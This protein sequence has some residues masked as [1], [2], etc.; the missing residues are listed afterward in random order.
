MISAANASFRDDVLPVLTSVCARC[1]TGDGPGTAHV[2]MDT[3]GEIAANAFDIGAAVSIGK[4]PPWP[5]SDLGPAYRGD[6]SLDPKQIDAI[7]RWAG[8]GGALDVDP[9]TAVAAAQGPIGLAD[10]DVELRPERGYDGIAGQPD[11]YRCFVYDPGL[12]E[13]RHI[14]GYEFVADQTEVV[15]H[16]IGYL[17]PAGRRAQAAALDGSDGQ[18]GWTCF[19][20]SGLG[21]RDIFLG[22]APGQAPTTFDAGAGL[23]MGAG[24][25]IVVQVHYHFEVDAPA[26]RSTL[27]LRWAEESDSSDEIVV[28]QYFAPAEIPCGPD[29][30]GP[31]C[32]RSAAMTRALDRYGPDGVQAD[33]ILGLCGRTAA[34]VGVLVDAIASASCDQPV[35][36]PGRVVSVLGHTHELGRSFRM[37]LNPGRADERILL[38]IPEWDFQWQFNYVPVEEI[39]LARSDVIRVECTWDRSL[40]DPALEPAYVFW[41]DGTDDEMC[42][43]TIAT[44]GDGADGGE[45]GA[46]AAIVSS[47]GPTVEGCAVAALPGEAVPSGDELVGALHRCADPSVVAERTVDV[48]GS[49]F[50]A[51]LTDDLRRCLTD[52][53]ADAGA[54]AALVDAYTGR[55]DDAT[56]ASAAATFADCAPLGSVVARALPQLELSA[57]T[58]VCLDDN[59]RA[60]VEDIFTRALR[61]QTQRVPSVVLS[62]LSPD[63]LSGALGS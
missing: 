60:D 24:D 33:F 19:G 16:A 14:A 53:Y 4:M 25:F 62:C 1:H 42:F 6:W 44:V 47:L 36:N 8:A 39:V 28:G 12:R 3:A 22:W 52:R 38:D 26:D 2:R 23:P 59:G 18:D 48:V 40:R 54:L 58:I 32:V 30:R 13:P 55:A 29:E 10:V 9:A 63:E 57:S 17:I 49:L 5:A 27:R 31:L 51:S 20:G 7:V 45:H 61:G 37:T 21:V 41:A 15:H 11:E 43:A 50:G 46:I 34:Q 56:V 35:N